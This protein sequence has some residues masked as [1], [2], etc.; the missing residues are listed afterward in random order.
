MKVI[1]IAKYGEDDILEDDLLDIGETYT[2]EEEK[3]RDYPKEDSIGAELLKE[4]PNPYYILKEVTNV[5][6]CCNE[7]V[8]FW[9][10]L[11]KVYEK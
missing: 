3:T 8:S 11:F 1:C 5:C 6:T 2:V 4:Y 10:G 7:R 9:H